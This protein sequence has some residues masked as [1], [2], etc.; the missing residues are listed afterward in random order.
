MK[1]NSKL[2]TFL[3]PYDKSIQKLTLE[4]RN[5]IVDLVP[6]ANELIYDNYNAVAIA[7]S[8]SEKL[9]DTFCH[10][11]VY[12]KH[13]NFGFN[14]GSELS[15]SNVKLEGK[16]KLIQHISV[17]KIEQFQKKDIEKLI[18]EAVGLSEKLNTCLIEKKTK[19]KSIIMS[20]SE[21]KKRP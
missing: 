7:F 16:G 4:L 11:A 12:S 21:K 17:N 10:I 3:L 9:K 2:L 1:T 8:K 6:E 18:W 20:I 5:F 15:K 19:P 13:I 14:R